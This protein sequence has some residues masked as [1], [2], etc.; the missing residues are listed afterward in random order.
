M[1]TYSG[2]DV[3]SHNGV[4]NWQKV[5]SH[6]SFVM[7]RAGYGQ[8]TI[9]EMF[10]TN[11]YGC[12]NN[13]IPFGV[14]WFSYAHSVNDAIKEAKKCLSVVKSFSLSLPIAFDFE[15]DSIEHAKKHGVIIDGKL[16][17]EIAKAFL[18]EVKKSGY[19]VLL[20]TNPDLWNKGF[21]K[22]G[23]AYPIWCA[24]WGADKPGVYCD[25]WQDSCSGTMEGIETKVDTNISYKEYK[26]VSNSETVDAKIKA[27]NDTFCAKYKGVATAIINGAYGNGNTRKAKLIAE[28]L[29]PEFAQ[30]LVNAMV[31]E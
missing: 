18:D 15:Y 30:A 7:I 27:V 26:L 14:Y 31:G 21:K 1:N 3:S 23:T 8:N 2:I 24:H 6:V 11:A 13:K 9:D 12:T 17:A 16:M 25:I 22:L 5:K 29:D 19:P 10:K 28:K 20:Y 4:I